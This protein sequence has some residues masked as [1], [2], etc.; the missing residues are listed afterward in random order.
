M[1]PAALTRTRSQ[2]RLGVSCAAILGALVIAACGSSNDQTATG[3]EVSSSLL[4]YSHCMRSHGVPG[5]PDPST[6]QGPNAMGIDGYNF[7][8]PIN[9]NQQSPAYE[10]ADQACGGLVDGAGGSAHPLPAKAK[11]AALAHA[12]CMRQH[13]APNYPDPSFSANGVTQSQRAGGP[14]LNPQA[15]AFQQAQ[16]I[17]Q[18]GAR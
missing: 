13:G 6:S 16:K 4:M 7:N 1:C 12:E 5:F 3:R 8:L 18:P 11:E 2:F 17:C 10:S 14:G 15:P 9:L